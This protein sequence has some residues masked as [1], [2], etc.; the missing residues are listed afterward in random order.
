MPHERRAEPGAD[1]LRA[2][3][4]TVLSKLNPDQIILFG[5]GARG[6]MTEHSDLD[7]LVIK[8]ATDASGAGHHRWRN[9][10]TRRD[11]DVFVSTRTDAERAREYAGNARGS[12]VET[13]RTIYTRPGFTPIET[14]P[15]QARETAMGTQRTLFRP[16]RAFEFLSRAERKWARANR[17]DEHP[18]DRCEDL[19]AAME[20]ALKGLTIAQG[21]QI[22]HTHNLNVL[23]DDAE[24]DGE[25]IAGNRDAEQLEKLSLYAGVYQYEDPTDGSPEKT[26]DATKDTGRN[27]VSHARTRIPT[28]VEQTRRRLD[29]PGTPG[30]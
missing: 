13:G 15:R 9:G 16:D 19:Q 24:K 8:E 26:W 21:R 10:T 27:V 25:R 20:Q 7:L 14:G 12:A 3:V 1:E 28:L 18:T 5:S 29:S 11:I 2:A 17:P 23:W 22:T 30:T 4:E 6:E